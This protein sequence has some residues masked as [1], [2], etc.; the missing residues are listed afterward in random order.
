[1]EKGKMRVA[2]GGMYDMLNQVDWTVTKHTSFI[3][4]SY[5]QF[6]ELKYVGVFGYISPS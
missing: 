1:M 5:Q 2:S 6:I 4:V 3:S